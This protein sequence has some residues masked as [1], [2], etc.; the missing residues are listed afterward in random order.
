MEALRTYF[1]DRGYTVDG[2]QEPEEA[3]ALLACLRYDL[4]IADMRF[5]AWGG[6]E[7]LSLVAMARELNPAARVVVLTGAKTPVLEREACRVG[8]DLVLEK[9]IMLSSLRDAVARLDEGR[10]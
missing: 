6:T 7:G 1:G 2:A 3:E 9:P 5:S 10:R 8:A 4:V